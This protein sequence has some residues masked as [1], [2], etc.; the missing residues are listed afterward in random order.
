[1]S[2]N[3]RK[4]KMAKHG[5]PE[6]KSNNKRMANLGGKAL[7]FGL[8]V[9]TLLLNVGGC[10]QPT[11]DDPAPKKC[12]CPNG[13]VHDDPCGCDADDCVC[14]QPTVYRP[15]AQYGEPWDVITIKDYTKRA[16]TVLI[17]KLDDWIS[18]VI[19]GFADVSS[20]NYLLKLVDDDS[21]TD[22]D[23]SAGVLVINMQFL[24]NST[25]NLSDD[26][27]LN[28]KLKGYYNSLGGSVVLLHKS[29]NNIIRMANGTE[30]SL[31]EG[32]NVKF[33]LNYGV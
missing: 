23:V 1:M 31:S 18:T 32:K 26:S 19:G 22:V 25:G 21:I 9:T 13:T 4:S 15:W 33:G 29:S 24:E 3:K 7:A 8:G 16:N 28:N 20:F 14:A 10:K 5:I 6:S 17:Q 11:N 2:P 30:F 12:E 27:T